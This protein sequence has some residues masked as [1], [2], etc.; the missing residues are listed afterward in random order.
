M[1]NGGNSKIRSCY[2]D[3]DPGEE[4]TKRMY[5]FLQIKNKKHS[6]FGSSVSYNME[7]ANNSHHLEALLAS[8]FCLA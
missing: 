1:Q 3:A 2:L 8:L 6:N 5:V 4:A 7:L